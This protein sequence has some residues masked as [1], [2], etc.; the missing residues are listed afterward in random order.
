MIN[1]YHTVGSGGSKGYVEIFTEAES[2]RSSDPEI[3]AIKAQNAAHILTNIDESD[4]DMVFSN[5]KFLNQIAIVDLIKSM[6]I[7]SREELEKSE[8]PRIFLLQKLVEVCDMNMNR[9]RIEFSSMWREMKDHISTVGSNKNEQ[10]AVYAIDSLRQLA[11]KFLEKEELNNYQFQKNFLEPFNIIVLNNMHIR[12]NII[13]FIMS[14]MWSF[15]RQMTKN[16]RSGWEIIIEIFKFG[17]ENDSYDLSKEAIETLDIIL[18]KDNFIYVEEY[19][20]KIINCLVKFMNNSFEDHALLA[21]D[22]IERVS[23]YLG[24][25]NEFVERIIEKSREMFNTQQE[26]L[27]YKKRLW[28]CVLYELSKKSFWA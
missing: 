8:G 24:E 17:G 12:M 22:L 14:C 26:K 1:Y 25:S 7:V 23:T 10:V 4:I 20:E 15:A 18:R 3:E 2:L 16:L 9:A 6:C 11:K 21:L 19:F 5:S 13:Q 28:K 27:E